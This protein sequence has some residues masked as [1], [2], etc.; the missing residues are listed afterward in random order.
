MSGWTTWLQP[1]FF[2]EKLLG[3]NRISDK[4]S[5]SRH[6]T[7]ETGRENELI[8]LTERIEEEQAKDPSGFL[9]EF[10]EFKV[11]ELAGKLAASME[12]NENWRETGFTPNTFS[13]LEEC[14]GGLYLHVCDPSGH[15]ISFSSW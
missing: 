12:E 13:G 15:I 7:L 11:Q 14:P 5:A 1:F 10:N 4:A 3:F 6:L 2:Y 9:L 8:R